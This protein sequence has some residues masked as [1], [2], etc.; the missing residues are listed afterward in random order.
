MSSDLASTEGKSFF[1]FFLSRLRFEVCLRVNH[2]FQNISITLSGHM[3]H[4]FG[5]KWLECKYIC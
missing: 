2:G 3:V 5:H 4:I 1:F